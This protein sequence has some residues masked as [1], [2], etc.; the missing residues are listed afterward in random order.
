MWQSA[1]N[2]YT[3]VDASMLN[4]H[5]DHADMMLMRYTRYTGLKYITLQTV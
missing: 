3:A 2:K 5:S 1:T 4:V